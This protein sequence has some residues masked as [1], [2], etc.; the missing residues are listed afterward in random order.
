MGVNLLCH[1]RTRT[2]LRFSTDVDEAQ[3]KS[4]KDEVN[5]PIQVIGFDFSFFLENFKDEILV[6]I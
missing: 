3:E 6:K 5:R 1:L 4:T 2:H